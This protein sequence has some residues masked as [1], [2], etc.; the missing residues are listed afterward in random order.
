MKDLL[1]TLRRDVPDLFAN[2]VNAME[3]LSDADR[4]IAA[5]DTGKT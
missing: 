4:W 3:N 5:A 2:V 1:E